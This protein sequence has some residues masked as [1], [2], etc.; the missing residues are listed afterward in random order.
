MT[1]L[2]R[3]EFSTLCGL[4]SESSVRLLVYRGVIAQQP[5]SSCPTEA[6]I[7]A[8]QIP[9]GLVL[10][11]LMRLGI[12]VRMITTILKDGTF[13]SGGIFTWRGPV[14][15]LRIDTKQSRK[16]F[17]AQTNSIRKARA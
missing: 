17:G 4:Q 2:T 8:S 9:K 13:K 3:K 10:C 15:S 12:P 14:T 7:D 6:L 5:N 11:S 1:V 16:Y